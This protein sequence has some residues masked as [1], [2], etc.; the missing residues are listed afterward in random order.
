M[1]NDAQ[2]H[3]I[4]I[5]L[6]KDTFCQVCEVGFTSK[7]GFKRHLLTTRHQALASILRPDVTENLFSFASDSFSYEPPVCTQPEE[8]M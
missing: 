4:L 3:F 5:H 8:V 2:W 6:G 7:Y 1:P